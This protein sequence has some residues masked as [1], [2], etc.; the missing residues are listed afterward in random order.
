MVAGALKTRPRP[1]R[2]EVHEDIVMILK[3]NVELEIKLID[4]LLDLSRITSSK[5]ELKIEGVDLNE[6][7]RQVCAIC[8][9]QLAEN[10]VQLKVEL[11]EDVGLISADPARLQQVLWNV[12]KNAIKFTPPEGTVGV[13]TARLS[14][15]RCEV[16]VQD[17]GIGIPADILP[18]IF[19]AF[20]QGDAHITRQFGGLGLGLAIS[21]ALVELHGGTIRAESEGQGRGATFIVELPGQAPAHAVEAPAADASDDRNAKR[22]RLL[23]VED[24][25]D[26]ARALSRFL[27][28]AGMIV[29]SAGDVAS[30][31]AASGT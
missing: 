6:A 25:A 24:H 11:D 5:V 19:N 18:R 28:A 17:S 9:P 2:P 30:A 27:R 15:E 16:R 31:I 12:L 20:E 10:R 26:T 7:M 21:R 14:P 8:Q 23:L 1:R 13:R 3:R 29:I 4:D 22:I